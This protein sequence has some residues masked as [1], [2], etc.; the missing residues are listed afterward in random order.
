MRAP[1][2]V[3][4]PVL[5]A[6]DVLAGCAAALMEAVEVGLIRELI[7]SDGG[8]NDATRQIA[9]EIGALW[10]SGAPSRGGQLRR[11]CA[12]AKGEWILALHA[13]TQLQAGWSD[14]AAAHLQRSE[15]GYFKLAFASGGMPARIVAGWANLRSR[16]LGL[17]YGDQGLL[18]SRAVYQEVG[19]YEDMPLMEDVAM[20]RALS[21]RLRGLDARAV[22]SAQKY[23]KAGWLWRGGRNLW[24]LLRYF[25]GVPVER[26][27]AQYRRP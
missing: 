9:E 11:G 7:V 24:T 27:A 2:S 4:I 3:V 8:S 13:D 14:V 25:A 20:A 21:G 23:Q 18:I 15:A 6:G 12:V 10:V 26:L 5:N 19:G 16:V 22:T 1:I 17:P